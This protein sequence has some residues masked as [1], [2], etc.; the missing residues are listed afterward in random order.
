MLRQPRSLRQSRNSRIRRDRSRPHVL[1]LSPPEEVWSESRDQK[2]STPAALGDR[3]ACV[4]ASDEFGAPTACASQSSVIA[5]VAL[6]LAVRTR[7]FLE[8][9]N[10]PGR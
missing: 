9:C 10:K 2:A 3:E 5:N 6:A 7:T 1:A 8:N 4:Q